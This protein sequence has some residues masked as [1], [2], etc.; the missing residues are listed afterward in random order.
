MSEHEFSGRKTRLSNYRGK[1]ARRRTDCWVDAY[2]RHD[3]AG[4]EIFIKG[5]R[6]G[7]PPAGSD[8]EFDRSLAAFT[9]ISRRERAAEIATKEGMEATYGLQKK[10]DS[11]GA[12]AREEI[13]K[14]NKAPPT[15]AR[16]RQVFVA[17]LSTLVEKVD[18]DELREAG[19]IRCKQ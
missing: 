11:S 13:N 6:R 9:A 19:L 15:Q 18:D 4:K 1:K 12:I 8:Y 7:P 17:M 3:K 2:I 5:H 14:A 10:I 16:I